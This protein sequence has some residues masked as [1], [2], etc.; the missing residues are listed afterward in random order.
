[1]YFGKYRGFIN[2]DIW[3]EATTDGFCK[4]YRCSVKKLFVSIV[5]LNEIRTPFRLFL[6]QI[7]V[8]F[9][10]H[11][12]ALLTLPHP[13]LPIKRKQQ[14]QKTL[15]DF[16]GLLGYCFF[17]I[18]LSQSKFHILSFLQYHM[19]FSCFTKEKKIKE[20]KNNGT[21]KQWL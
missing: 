10:H 16:L 18:S 20:K 7:S 6:S 15:L 4:T 1:M 21:K 9:K 13:P 2:K 3:S 14:K 12:V 17:F 11:S 8:I 19:Y 5:V